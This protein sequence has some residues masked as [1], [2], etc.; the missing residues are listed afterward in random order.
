MEAFTSKVCRIGSQAC[1][2]AL[3]EVPGPCGVNPPE[4]L[5]R[6]ERQHEVHHERDVD[7]PPEVRFR[8]AREVDER[9]RR[10]DP[11]G[12]EEPED[13]TL[14]AWFMGRGWRT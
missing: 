7:A 1:E 6:D 11:Q 2:W 4:R 12:R 5:P 8:D 10:C 9:H 3:L 13:D 14:A